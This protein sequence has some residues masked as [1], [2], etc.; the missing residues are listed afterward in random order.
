VTSWHDYPAA[1]LGYTERPLMDWFCANVRPGE[2]WLD[3]GAHYGY[4]ALA[5][6]KLVGKRGRVFAFEP[7]LST[8]GCLESTRLLNDLT[9]LTVLPVG[10]TATE[11]SV[12]RVPLA[13]GMADHNHESIH[14][15]TILAVALDKVWQS[16]SPNTRIDGVKIDVQGMELAVLD[17]MKDTL[18]RWHPKLIVEV[19]EG[20]D[21][22][23][24]RGLLS[25][26]GY[27]STGAA[28]ESTSPATDKL[29]DDRSYLFLASDS[30]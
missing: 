2:I 26:V 6:S 28:I 15:T 5:L 16:L 29:E 23:S 13:R 11:L 17:G 30:V 1:L 14:A 12:M 3:V 20:V 10:L 8:V 19:H 9:Q 4:T 27:S 7:V 22:N 25:L 18:R 21:R 24:L